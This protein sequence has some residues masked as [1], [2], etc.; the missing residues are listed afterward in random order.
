VQQRQAGDG[1]DVDARAGDI[2]E[3]RRDDERHPAA[4]QLPG[5][6]AQVGLGEVGPGAD[7]DRVGTR[8]LQGV[9]DGAGGPDDRDPL[10]VR[11]LRPVDAGAD[12]VE[13]RVGLAAQLPDELGAAALTTD[14]D[15]LVQA[16]PWARARCSLWRR[17]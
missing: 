16:L 8:A 3:G 10:D 6:P 5:Q 9:D 2:G 17:A 1:P 7:G 15:D 14:D 11:P 12:D 13:A 4:L